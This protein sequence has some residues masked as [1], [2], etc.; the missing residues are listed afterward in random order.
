MYQPT[1]R[2]LKLIG[3]D[4]KENC[5]AGRQV[6]SLDKILIDRRDQQ[7]KVAEEMTQELRGHRKPG[8]VH[9]DGLEHCCTENQVGHKE[10]FLY[11]CIIVC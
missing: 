1:S 4:G 9:H 2:M 8:V 6:V 3:V 7:E 11:T 5:M 10:F